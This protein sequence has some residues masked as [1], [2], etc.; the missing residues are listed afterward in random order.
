MPMYLRTPSSVFATKI[1]GDF[2]VN[3]IR[4]VR[5]FRKNYQMRR[6]Y[7]HLLEMPEHMLDDVGLTRSQVEAARRRITP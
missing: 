6:D 5:K 7:K 1:A 4:T 3:V 2:A